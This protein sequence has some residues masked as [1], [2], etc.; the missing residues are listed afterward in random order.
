MTLPPV[1]YEVISNSDPEYAGQ[2]FTG[3]S[4]PFQYLGQV[5]YP[6]WEG[7]PGNSA[8]AFFYYPE[9]ARATTTVW[10]Q[11]GERYFNAGLDRGVL[12]PDGSAGVPWNG[13]TGVSEA[14]TGGTPTPLYLDGQK[15]SN[16]PMLEEFEA[17]I[18]AF[19]APLEFARATGNTAIANGLFLA[20]QPRETFGLSYRTFVGNDTDGISAG[21]Q[22]HMVY[23]ALAQPSQ[24]ANVT[25]STSPSPILYTWHITTLALNFSGHKPSA[26]VIVDSRYTPTWLLYTLEDILYGTPSTAPQLPTP[27][28]L[29]T[30]FT[31]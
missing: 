30:L 9:S 7:E 21:Y 31:S 27:Q 19:N 12:Y 5:V 14:P 4:P 23:G 20:Q 16:Y 26:H 17:N 2:P 24:V 28:D 25:L 6:F 8:S 15:Y 18:T 3:D 11:V 1:N 22:L 10:N 29:Y 13:L